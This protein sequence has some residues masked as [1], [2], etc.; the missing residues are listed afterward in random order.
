MR[1]TPLFRHEAIHN[2]MQTYRVQ[3]NALIFKVCFNYSS[4]GWFDQFYLLI[5]DACLPHCASLVLKYI[6]GIHCVFSLCIYIYQI[7]TLNYHSYF[8]C[9]HA[10]HGPKLGNKNESVFV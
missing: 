5:T 2:I 8:L 10:K 7:L 4:V 9:S 1:P 6:M 3:K